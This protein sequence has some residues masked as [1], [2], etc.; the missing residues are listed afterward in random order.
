MKSSEF[1]RLRTVAMS[2]SVSCARVSGARGAGA[3]LRQQTPCL[4]SGGARTWPKAW[5]SG[6]WVPAAAFR[7]ARS[8]CT[9]DRGA[10]GRGKQRNAAQWRRWAGSGVAYK[11]PQPLRR[12]W[13]G[14]EAIRAVQRPVDTC[15]ADH[16]VDTAIGASLLEPESLADA[17]ADLAVRTAGG[18]PWKRVATGRAFVGFLPSRARRAEH[19]GTV[20]RARARGRGIGLQ[21]GRARAQQAPPR[22]STLCAPP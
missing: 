14:Q 21:W 4:T 22:L 3:R 19:G 18:P 20:R 16:G 1:S 17:A 8:H 15:T 10:R 11:V 5:R 2:R 12:R 9:S 7:Y 6:A 13:G